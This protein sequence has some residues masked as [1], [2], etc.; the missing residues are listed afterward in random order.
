MKMKD[1]E[2]IMTQGKKTK[3]TRETSR[4]TT[5]LSHQEAG[6]RQTASYVTSDDLAEGSRDEIERSLKHQK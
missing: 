2:A 1:A 3:S 5:N 4:K 6:K